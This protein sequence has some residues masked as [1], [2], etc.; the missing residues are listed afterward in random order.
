MPKTQVHHNNY[1][2][3]YQNNDSIPTNEFY[4]EEHCSYVNSQNEYNQEQLDDN[5]EHEINISST[6][7]LLYIEIKHPK[8]QLLIDTGNT[9]S[10]LWLSVADKFYPNGIY[11]SNVNIKTSFMNKKI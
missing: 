1:D 11:H 8:L 6:N 5:L 4:P 2:D 3:D 9:K 7:P 10:T